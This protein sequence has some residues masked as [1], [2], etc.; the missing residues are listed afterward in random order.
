MDIP[1]F[2]KI[3]TRVN[4]NTNYIF[5]IIKDNRKRKNGHI[6]N[7]I[8]KAN[9]FRFKFIEGNHFEKNKV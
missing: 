9:I 1:A 2:E 3:E 6:Q 5:L 7:S 4:C 8:D